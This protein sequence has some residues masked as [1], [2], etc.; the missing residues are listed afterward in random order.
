MAV[1]YYGA[2]SKANR[3]RIIAANPDLATHPNRIIVGTKYLIPTEPAADRSAPSPRDDTRPKV[4]TNQ[5][6]PTVTYTTRPGDS[7]WKIAIEQCGD[8]SLVA[9]IRN[10]N[11]DVIR[12]EIIHPNLVLKLPAKSS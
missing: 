1:K 5:P 4:L 9:R 7:L 12:G 8:G 2:N 6:E 3:D 11:K 10:L